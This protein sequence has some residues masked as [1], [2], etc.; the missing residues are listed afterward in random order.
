MK[1]R[2]S[3]V[4]KSLWPETPR[5]N[6]AMPIDQKKQKKKLKIWALKKKKKNRKARERKF[7]G[8]EK[9]RGEVKPY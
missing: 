8:G 5:N 2:R 7:L 1:L 4:K 6:P 3:H 9:G